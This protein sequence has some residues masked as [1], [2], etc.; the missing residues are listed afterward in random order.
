MADID[1]LRH[2]PSDIVEV[3]NYAPLD[4]EDMRTFMGELAQDPSLGARALEFC[5]LTATRTKETRLAVWGEID[6]D[7]KIVDHPQKPNEGQKGQAKGSCRALVQCHN[8]DPD[9]DQGR[10]DTGA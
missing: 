9:R 3:E 10:R 2:S 8:G 6:L 5:I 4:A 7:Q 1:P